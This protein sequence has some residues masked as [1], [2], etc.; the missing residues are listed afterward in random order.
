MQIFSEREADLKRLSKPLDCA[1]YAT[2]IWDETLYRVNIIVALAS[3]LLSIDMLC[4]G[5][6]VVEDRVPDDS[7][8]SA[9]RVE[10]ELVRGDSRRRRSAAVRTRHVPRETTNLNTR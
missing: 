7:Q 5:S 2:S 8:R 3:N 10:P 9:D 1:C 4:C 6:G